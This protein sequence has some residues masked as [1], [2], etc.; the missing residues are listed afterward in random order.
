MSQRFLPA[1]VLAL[2]VALAAGPSP[3]QAP[4]TTDLSPSSAA[5]SASAAA[6]A[7]LPRRP[8]PA[9]STP[10]APPPPA[11]P[12]PRLQPGT[13]I[14]QAELEVLVD[15]LVRQSMANDHIAGVAVSVVQNGQVV[16]DKGYGFAGPGRPVDPDKTLFRVGSISNT[17]TWIALM[18]EVEAGHIRLMEPINLYLPE[19]LQ[20]KDQGF[21]RPILVRDLPTHTPGFEDRAL[22]QLFEQD[23]RRVRALADYLRQERPRRVRE[24]G[25]FS[26]YSN[27]G[28]ALAGEAVSWVNG[29]PYQDIVENEILRPLH[30]DHT[31]FRE[32]YPARADL[33]APMSASLAGDVSTGYRWVGG[34][35][36]PQSFEYVTQAAPAGAASSSAGD[37]ARYM[38]MIL[39]GGQLDGATIY[40]ATTAQGFRTTLQASAPGVAGWD[41]GFMEIPL[42]GGFTGRGHGGD[43]LWFHSMLVTVPEL[44]LGVFVTTN[45]DTGPRLTG[46]LAQRIVGQ[47]YAP[48]QDLPLP[49]SPA[50][51]DAR[52]VYAGTYLTTRRPYGGLQKFVFLV[53]GQTR[54]AVTEDGRL[55]AG[56]Q[57][58][59]P[60]GPE[61]RF[62]QADGPLKTAFTLDNGRAVRWFP[63][64]GA[65][66]FDR[67]GPLFQIPTLVVVAVLAALASIA[68]LVGIF[69][70]DR[71]ESRQTPMQNRAGLVQS[72]IAVLWLTA[73]ILAGSWAAGAADLGNV[74]YH[75]PGPL[76]T[77]ASA[78]ALT[79]A[80][81]TLLTIVM[82][83]S[84]WR[85]GRRVDSWTSWRKLRFTLT[86]VIF[87]ALS[88][89]LGLWGGLAP[90]S[91]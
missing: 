45:T 59:V 2:G 65:V 57:N 79:A 36:T 62:R 13:P 21:K 68:T 26:T 11:A 27:Y 53:I 1:L 84:V 74:M 55:Q 72:T 83:P 54:I 44:N 43:T 48:R 49:G 51:A 8:V 67:I 29:H 73:F 15:G 82:A 52:G 5:A 86:T 88:V 22:G 60:D 24:A 90:W 39:G 34:N 85:G 20:I 35:F 30:L 80:V 32:P 50:L 71:R 23:P 75:W 12:G 28:A 33:P 63:A 6:E 42:P 4:D 38:L 56:G 25:A 46:E 14:P 76:L 31:T 77:L 37:M 47:F 17:F 16:L 81:L 40:D 10:A 78:C 58:W 61:G 64:S 19:P 69:T 3:A 87:A 18:K 7:A 41:D 91:G 70:R 89:M 9:P 66:A